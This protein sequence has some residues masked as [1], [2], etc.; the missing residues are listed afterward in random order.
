MDI[1]ETSTCV[2]QGSSKIDKDDMVRRI[3]VIAIGT[4]LGQI[5][6]P[7]VILILR[8][9]DSWALNKPKTEVFYTNFPKW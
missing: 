6:F 1:P 7:E 5:L 8:S 2:V 9:V 3:F 4:S